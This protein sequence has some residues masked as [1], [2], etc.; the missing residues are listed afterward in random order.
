MTPTPIDW[1]LGAILMVAVPAWAFFTWPGF[2]AAA[3]ANAPGVRTRAYLE[4]V[5][6]QWTLCLAVLTWWLV[7]GRPWP[8]L[9]LGDPL[10]VRAVWVVVV[11]IAGLAAYHV[12]SIAKLTSEALEAGKAQIGDVAHLLP[13]TPREHRLFHV[14]AVTAGVCEELAYRGFVP[15]LLGAVMPSWAAI[16]TATAVFAVGHAY[17]GPTGILKT[18][19]M[20]GLMVGI[21]LW[22]GTLWP[23]MMLHVIVDLHGGFVGGR[24]AGANR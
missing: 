21:V 23:A 1:I 8:T 10:E 18:G 6:S 24:I 3:K 16:T 9:G 17:Q 22:S 11:A 14:V 2:L 12:R 15:W 7:R 5:V 4:V 20:G 19:V 13:H